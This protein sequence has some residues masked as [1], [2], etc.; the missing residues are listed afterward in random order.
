MQKF[1]RYLRIA[2]SA[3]CLTACVLLIVLWVRSYWLVDLSELQLP[4]GRISSITSTP[5]HLTLSWNQPTILPS[6]TYA[7]A[8]YRTKSMAAAP[9]ALFY[10]AEGF[11]FD[12]YECRVPYWFAV[13]IMGPL[14]AT[15]WLRWR[16]SLR[17]LLVATTLVAV[18]LGVIVYT[19]HNYAACRPIYL[20]DGVFSLLNLVDG[21]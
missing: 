15:P 2:F 4:K 14:A 16:F 21:L 18:V 1:L 5:G 7:I 11:R 17:T 19:G 10:F 9:W 3:T 12:R 13:L 8:D 6:G 20:T